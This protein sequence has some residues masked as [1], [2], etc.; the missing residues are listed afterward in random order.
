MTSSSFSTDCPRSK[1]F[2]NRGIWKEDR[3]RNAS[4]RAPERVNLKNRFPPSS[5]QSNKNIK[6]KPRGYGSKEGTTF[7]GGSSKESMAL[8]EV[9]IRLEVERVGEKKRQG[10]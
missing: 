1:N 6:R 5:L 9:R 4:R 7:R 10:K 3:S 8:K 2:G